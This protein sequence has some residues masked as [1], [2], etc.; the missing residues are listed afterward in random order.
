MR[1]YLESYKFMPAGAKFPLVFEFC[2]FFADSVPT[3]QNLIG[4]QTTPSQTRCRTLDY[5]KVSGMYHT[6]FAKIVGMHCRFLTH[7]LALLP[8][9]S[10]EYCVTVVQLLCPL[11]VIHSKTCRIEHCFGTGEGGRKGLSLNSTASS[12]HGYCLGEYYVF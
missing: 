4:Q 10:V 6:I 9:L 1:R 11:E 2:P 7:L 12:V 5:F 3:T 8:L